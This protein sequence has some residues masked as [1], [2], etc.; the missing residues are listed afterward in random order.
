MFV[1]LFII[2]KNWRKPK[3]PPIDERLQRKR[4][5]EKRREGRRE[6]KRKKMYQ[7]EKS[8]SRDCR[9][10]LIH[11]ASLRFHNAQPYAQWRPPWP[12]WSWA[13][14][15]LPGSLEFPRLAPHERCELLI[16]QAD[17]QGKAARSCRI[18]AVGRGG[19]PISEQGE[20][21]ISHR[22]QK[23]VRREEV[24]G[25]TQYLLPPTVLQTQGE[26]NSLNTSKK[27]I[28]SWTNS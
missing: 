24:A 17:V 12:R 23:S 2:A 11:Q 16:P 13:P 21:I 15:G 5:R 10:H 28:K 20:K 18:A 4:K 27:A 19:A 7:A 26:T 9:P 8:C 25:K 3:C 6:R 14:G 22:T 1:G